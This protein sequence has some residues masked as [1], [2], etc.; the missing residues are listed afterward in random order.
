MLRAFVVGQY[1]YTRRW[2]HS[3]TPRFALMDADGRRGHNGKEECASQPVITRPQSPYGLCRPEKFFRQLSP[4]FHTLHCCVTPN[5]FAA[6]TKMDS[7]PLFTEHGGYS[8]L[9]SF[10][11]TRLVYD[12][13]VRFCNRY[14][15][16]RNPLYEQM[17][18]AT[19]SGVQNI[20][21]GNIASASSI[22]I[23]IELTRIART[24]LETLKIAYEEFLRQQNMPVWSYNDRRHKALKGHR[25][26]TVAEV[27]HWI[28]DEH[29][30]QSIRQLPAV[31]SIQFIPSSLPEITAN[32]ALSLNRTACRLLDWNLHR[33]VQN[34][35]SE[36]GI[37]ERRYRVCAAHRNENP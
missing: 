28:L 13:T 21:K 26:A 35:K 22:K 12:L 29:K 36:S 10:Q 27:V 1:S 20:A 14:I 7:E 2:L 24:S 5:P 19:R 31:P 16:R 6:I 33:L 9:K 11:I 15:E 23:E 30:R 34:F 18:F 32:V 8:E 25:C 3:E 17:I 4:L 37:A